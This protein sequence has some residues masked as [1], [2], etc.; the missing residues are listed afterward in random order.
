MSCF[1]MRPGRGWADVRVL[2]SGACVGDLQSALAVACNVARNGC[3]DVKWELSM[4]ARMEF[5]V[6]R[7]IA[8]T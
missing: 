5:E 3:C 2:C 4:Y 6:D 8:A 7:A 1:D